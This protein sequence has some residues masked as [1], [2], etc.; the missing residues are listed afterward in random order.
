MLSVLRGARRRA[1]ALASLTAL[2]VYLVIWSLAVWAPFTQA[3]RF[4]ALPVLAQVAILLPAWLGGWLVA[5]AQRELIAHGEGIYAL[6]LALTQVRGMRLIGLS[7][8]AIMALALALAFLTGDLSARFGIAGA[9]SALTLF[10]LSLPDAPDHVYH[11]QGRV[12][13][14]APSRP[15]SLMVSEPPHR[16]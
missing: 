16:G 2:G 11:P 4:L 9:L 14:L 1:I 5:Q 8:S 10:A 6:L 3:A 13:A 15:R 7:L 12:L